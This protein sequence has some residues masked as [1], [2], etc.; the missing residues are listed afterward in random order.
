MPKFKRIFGDPIAMYACFFLFASL[1]EAQEKAGIPVTASPYVEVHIDEV[2]GCRFIKSDPE[3][4]NDASVAS[5]PDSNI[6]R[7]PEVAKKHCSDFDVIPQFKNDKNIAAA[8]QQC[9]RFY[10]MA[11]R[12]QNIFCS[13]H[14]DVAAFEKKS[15][16]AAQEDSVGKANV[17]QRVVAG[18][19]R[20]VAGINKKYMER[21][22]GTAQKFKA[23][24]SEYLKSISFMNGQ[25]GRDVVREASCL[26]NPTGA[27]TNRDLTST[28]PG[29]LRELLAAANYQ[30]AQMTFS[31]MWVMVRENYKT[32]N[33]VKQKAE[34]NAGKSEMRELGIPTVF[35]QSMEK[36]AEKGDGR[37]LAGPVEGALTGVV[38]NYIT[39]GIKKRFPQIA[40]GWA[41]IVGGTL[42]VVY[43]YKTN[44]RIMY[45]ETAATFLCMLASG[46]AC[47]FSNVM[48][49]AWRSQSALANEYRQFT[50][51]QLKKDMNLTSA[52]VMELWG[53]SKGSA[54]CQK[55]AQWEADCQEKRPGLPSYSGSN[56]AR[57]L[58]PSR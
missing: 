19:N 51:A 55:S 27:A 6:G 48:V 28:T 14:A 57:P 40:G 11:L 22:N 4:K 20:S 56:C 43:Q 23:S 15:A 17:S 7:A 44:K 42:V 9:M 49:A 1:A 10:E 30:Y 25:A 54:A 53:S 41:S 3:T 34:Q 50:H 24:Y 35:Q 31:Y 21:I 16:V 52:K 2:N 33:E 38:Q 12:I 45:P 39:E 46:G 37:Y 36:D 29:Y 5:L 8:Q 13:Y 18:E 32:L 58:S 47:V 26:S